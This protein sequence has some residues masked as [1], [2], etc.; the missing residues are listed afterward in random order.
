MTRTKFVLLTALI[1]ATAPL[2][3]PQTRGGDSSAQAGQV[4]LK[5]EVDQ[6][7]RQ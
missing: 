7:F 3:L 2:A 1:C 6:L 5:Q 4:S